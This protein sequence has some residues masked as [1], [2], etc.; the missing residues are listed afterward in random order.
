[1]IVAIVAGWTQFAPP[2]TPTGL[3][4]ATG[5]TQNAV[6]WDANIDEHVA[7][8]YVYGGTSPNPT[9]LLS[10]VN[11]PATSYLHTGLDGGKTYYYRITAVNAMDNESAPTE[12]A[13]AKAASHELRAAS[14]EKAA[15]Y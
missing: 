3:R 9:D 1:M 4:T 2:A 12:D 11:A 13:V 8:Y 10:I 5:N 6:S 14:F 7:S 15:S